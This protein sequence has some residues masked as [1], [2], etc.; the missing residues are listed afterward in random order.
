MNKILLFVIKFIIGWLY[1]QTSICAY[2]DIFTSA[3]TF[4]RLSVT[5]G[6]SKNSI[7]T[8]D[9]PTF[10]CRVTDILFSGFLVQSTRQISLCNTFVL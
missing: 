10:L 1:A 9:F 8:L 3:L 4:E 2:T 6:A 7:M 5:I